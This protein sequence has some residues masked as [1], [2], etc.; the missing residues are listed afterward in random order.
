MLGIKDMATM[1]V[2]VVVLVDFFRPRP[3][4]KPKKKP[5]E[6]HSLER[7]STRPAPV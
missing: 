5:V 7:D 1:A 2:A 6:N 4:G 3:P